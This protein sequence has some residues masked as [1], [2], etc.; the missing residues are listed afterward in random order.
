MA[1][2]NICVISLHCPEPECWSLGAQNC[3][4]DRRQLEEMLKRGEEIRAIGE[5]CHHS[6][7]LSEAIKRKLRGIL[8]D[9]N[10]EKKSPPKH[11]A[12]RITNVWPRPPFPIKPN[13][14]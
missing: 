13:V 10:L 9:Y 4:F 2:S 14:S 8:W 5:T 6:W 3:V 1:V 7:S 11:E 12:T